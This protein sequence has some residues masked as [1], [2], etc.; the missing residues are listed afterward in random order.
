MDATL[1]EVYSDQKERLA[2]HS[3]GGVGFHPLPCF[4]DN[5][6]RVCWVA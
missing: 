2:A 6:D 4:L 3:Q 5:T 1:V